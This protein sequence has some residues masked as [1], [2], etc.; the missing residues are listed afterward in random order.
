M[1]RARKRSEDE[2]KNLYFPSVNLGGLHRR[3]AHWEDK[4]PLSRLLAFGMS[5]VNTARVWVDE[6]QLTMP[7]YRDRVVTV[8]Q[9]TDEAGST[10]RWGKMWFGG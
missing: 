8:Y 3:T 4:K 6:K 2:W 5:L 10:C 7:G 9:D 1:R